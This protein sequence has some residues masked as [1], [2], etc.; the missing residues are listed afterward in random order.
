MEVGEKFRKFYLHK[1]L[2]VRHSAWFDN[3]IRGLS[4]P[5][6][7]SVQLPDTDA[8]MCKSRLYTLD[9]ARRSEMSMYITY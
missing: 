1:A 6:D 3:A 4:D 7:E 5:A 8:G 2:L 9:F